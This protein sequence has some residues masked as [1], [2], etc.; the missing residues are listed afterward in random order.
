MDKSFH[1]SI[2]VEKGMPTTLASGCTHLVI[3]GI[4][5]NYYTS[6]YKIIGRLALL[7]L[8]RNTTENQTI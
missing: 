5:M 3:M 8:S 7:V 2:T 6:A 1:A 4:F